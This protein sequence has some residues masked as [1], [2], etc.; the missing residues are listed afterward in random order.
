MSDPHEIIKVRKKGSRKMFYYNVKFAN[1]ESTVILSAGDPVDEIP[2]EF[3]GDVTNVDTI[4]EV[5][6]YREVRV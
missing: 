1:G 4:C 6:P 5:S 2:V 3:Q